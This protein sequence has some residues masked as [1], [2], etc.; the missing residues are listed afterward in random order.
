MVPIGFAWDW[1]T[2]QTT[3]LEFM[4]TPDRKF[5]RDRL[6]EMGMSQ[7]QLG[8]IMGLDHASVNRIFSGERGCS[9]REAT[10][11]A[12]HLKLPLPMISKKLGVEMG[13]L[14]LS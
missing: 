4:M 5:F 12:R 3:R 14:D 8:R 13:D 11:L 6:I 7:R 2:S 10:D 9:L 1:L